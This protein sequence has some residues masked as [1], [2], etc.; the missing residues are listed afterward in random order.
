V[1]RLGTEGWFA[2]EER[3][4]ERRRSSQSDSR[5]TTVVV[6][7]LIFLVLFDRFGRFA[8]ESSGMESEESE[9]DSL[10][11]VRGRRE[12]SRFGGERLGR[13]AVAEGMG[14][15]GGGRTPE[16][17]K[18]SKRENTGL[19]G[20]AVAGIGRSAGETSRAKPQDLPLLLLGRA[21]P[22]P[23]KGLQ[24]RSW[25]GFLWPVKS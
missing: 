17:V 1:A 25:L 21:E 3:G 18:I 24:R 15:G 11:A 20:L 6:G 5:S 23:S 4:E 12:G 22:L 16:E 10:E 14:G 2:E 9:S 7:S 19:A 8:R 13:V